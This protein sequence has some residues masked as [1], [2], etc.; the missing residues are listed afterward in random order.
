[1]NRFATVLIVLAAFGAPFFARAA[2][3]TTTTPLTVYFE[4]PTSS[5]PVGSALPV[6]V[7]LDSDEPVNAYSFSIHY[8][9]DLLNLQGTN[10]ANSII[11]IQRGAPTISGSGDVVVKGGSATPFA[12]SG[13]EVIE[14]DFV[15]QATGVATIS[16]AGAAVYLANGKGTKV[17]PQ[18][19]SSTIAI[20]AASGTAPSSL[21]SPVVFPSAMNDLVPPQ[22][23]DL[24]FADDPF[25]A[26]QTLFTFAVSDAGSG[27]KE[28]D[29]RYRSGFFWSAWQA[30][31]NPVS[32]SRGAW[33]VDLRAID[34]AGNVTEQTL[35]NWGAFAWFAGEVGAIAAAIAII[36]VILYRFLL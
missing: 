29:V 26:D 24:S 21:S 35:Y 2:T 22:I 13:G 33:E 34:N 23:T 36:I 9:T 10:N 15:P 11:T 18:M 14:L 20:V 32:L 30:A 25:N 17:V 27:M 6:K 19:R 3:A 16:F 7:L 8:A 28:T 1:M 5:V 4:A 12:G 31:S